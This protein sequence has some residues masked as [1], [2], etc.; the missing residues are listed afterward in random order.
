MSIEQVKLRDQRQQAL[1]DLAELEQQVAAGDIDPDTA[2]RLQAT[3]RAEL[4]SADRALSELEATPEEP[5][6]PG[7]SKQ[8]MVAGAAILILSFIGIVVM[9][10][11]FVVDREDSTLQGVAAGGEELDLNEV[12][13]A[14]LEAVIAANADNPMINGMRLALGE[15]YFQERLYQEAFP[16][17]QAVLDNDPAPGEAGEALSRLGWMVYDGNNQ[18]EL[19]R[20]LLE[21]SLEAR[22]ADP[23][24]TYL[25]AQVTW[26]GAGDPAAAVPL[27]E[28][29]L[30]TPGLDPEVA[31]TVEAD[32]AVAE[33]GGA[34]P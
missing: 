4:E 3:Y 30:A 14:T 5:P 16:H 34:C 9:V 2:R 27:L 20:S 15:R 10:N 22:P 32:L 28:S 12:S 33:A 18:V 25:L 24:T 26:C 29:V 11:A 13:N 19:A 31:Q 17:Y 6:P 7:R 21:R 23:L 8:R 1:R